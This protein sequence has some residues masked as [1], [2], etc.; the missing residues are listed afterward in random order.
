MPFN[1]TF[2]VRETGQLIDRLFPSS[3]AV[4]AVLTA[5]NDPAKALRPGQVADHAPFAPRGRTVAKAP[6]PIV[7]ASFAV[8]PALVGEAS[9]TLGC[10]FTVNGRAIFE[11]RSH[12]LRTLK[13]AGWAERS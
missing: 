2:C 11:S 9:R 12:R 10:K 3:A 6:Y 8:D 4:P 1:T 5:E 7:S 13:R